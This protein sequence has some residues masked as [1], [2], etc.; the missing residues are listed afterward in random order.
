MNHL[1]AVTLI[2]VLASFLVVTLIGFASAR[3]R[4]LATLT[5]LNE[6]GLAC[7]RIRHLR[8]LVPAR[9]RHLH[10]LHLHR[11]AR[12]GLR[13]RRCRVLRAGVHDHGL[14]DRVHLRAAALVG[15]PRAWLRHPRR[16]RPGQARLAGPRARGGGDRDPGHHA[17]DLSPPRGHRVG[18][19]R[20]GNRQ[21]LRQRLYQ[22]PAADHRVRRRGGLHLPGRTA[23]ASPDRIRQG[24]PHLPDGHRRDDLHPGPA[25]RLG[26]YLRHRLGAPANG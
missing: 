23:R 10:R 22:G 14:P 8:Q 26:A 19:D 20:D 16:V 6:W 3:W 13:H 15:R 18:A 9:R 24:H 11:R 2:I 1:N 17:R 7:L 5:H 12:A 21:H 25:R 4:P